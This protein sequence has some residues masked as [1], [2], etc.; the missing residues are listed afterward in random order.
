[1][2]QLAVAVSALAA[3][4]CATMMTAGSHVERG[5]DFAQYRT[6]DWGEA[7]ALPTGDPRLDQD[8]F[9]QDHM[10]G[11]VER[12]LAAKGLARV[13]SGATPDLRVH[14]HASITRRLD[15]RAAD[16][17][18]GSCTGDDCLGEVTEFEAGTLV[19]D[20]VDV[21]TNRV[22]WRGWAQDSVEGVLDNPD[23][24]E[25]QINQAVARIMEQLPRSLAA[26]SRTGQGSTR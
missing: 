7:D 26:S 12:Q 3:A 17:G 22:I 14:Y 9:F 2:K 25:A 10:L 21:R 5:L 1:V 6:Y 19:L 4:G 13:A 15:V 18:Y 16:S 24:M 11:A 8:P 23:R 20:L